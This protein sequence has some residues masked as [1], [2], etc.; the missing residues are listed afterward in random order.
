MTAYHT[1]L[2]QN[3]EWQNG[4]MADWQKGGM[5]EWYFTTYLIYPAIFMVHTNDANNAD[6]ANDTNG[7]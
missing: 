7:F 3:V 4:R 2:P 6:N 1:I 5:A